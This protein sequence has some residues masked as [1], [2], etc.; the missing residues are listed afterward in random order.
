VGTGYEI[1]NMGTF[2]QTIEIAEATRGEFQSVEAMVD[3]GAT[4]TSV[5]RPF[6][7]GLGITAMDSHSFLLANRQSVEYDIAQVRVQVDG[8]ERY[9]ICIFG[10]ERSTPL[11]GALTLEAFGLGVDPVNQRLAPVQGYL[12]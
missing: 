7:E 8:R 4:Y 10:E 12:V 11:L 9:T 1:V 5:P 3:T 2:F 6:L